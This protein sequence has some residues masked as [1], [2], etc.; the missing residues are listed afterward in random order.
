MAQGHPA[1]QPALTLTLV[2]SLPF[3]PSLRRQE[4][5]ARSISP[6]SRSL[7][8]ASSEREQRHFPIPFSLSFLSL[9]RYLSSPSLWH[10]CPHPSP[11]PQLPVPA[12]LAPRASS[13]RRASSPASPC[14]HLPLLPSRAPC[15][16]LPRCPLA[17]VKHQQAVLAIAA[18]RR[19]SFASAPHRPPLLRASA[20]PH[21]LAPPPSGSVKPRCTPSS[22]RHPLFRPA[23]GA[24]ALPWPL[25]SSSFVGPLVLTGRSRTTPS[26]PSCTPTRR[27]RASGAS[28]RDDQNS[29]K[30]LPLCTCDVLRGRVRN[31]IWNLKR[32]VP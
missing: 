29:A 25:P 30:S 15:W 18:S 23:A 12:S 11:P 16:L 26:R 22:P 32:Q 31:W 3:F 4:S 28:S 17:G 1:A 19:C 13:S 6:T 27:S 10:L 8:H 24:R 20:R 14:R 2:R 7:P 5:P 21:R 9:V